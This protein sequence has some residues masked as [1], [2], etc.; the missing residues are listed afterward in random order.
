MTATRDGY[1]TARA[2]SDA[3]A[4]ARPG[5]FTTS[6]PPTITGDAQVDQTLTASPGSWSPEAAPAYQWLVDGDPVAG[7]TGPTYS[8]GVDDVRKQVSVQ[9]TMSLPGYDTAKVVSTATSA[10]VPGTFRNTSDASIAGTPRV[11]VTLTAD[12]GGWSPEPHFSWQWTADG[13]PISGAT[14][15]TFT[16]SPAEVGKR[17]AVEVTA[18]RPG[19]LTA[20]VESPVTA[21]VLPGENS[22]TQRPE[23]SGLPDVGETLTATPGTWAVA[24]SSVAYQWYADGV[25]IDGATSRRFTPGEAQLDQRLKVEVTARADG[26]EARTASSSATGPVVLGQVAFATGPSIS[27]TTLVGRTLTAATGRFTPSEA[28]PSYQ[29]LR[30]GDPIRGATG[31]TYELQPADV[32]YRVAV[33]VTLAAPHW[34]PTSAVARS[35]LVKSVPELTVS[36][37]SHATWAGISLRVVTPGLPDPDGK[38]RVYE[39]DELLGTIV[40]TDHRGYLRLDGLSAGTHH[41]VLRYTGPGPQAPASTRVD[42]PIG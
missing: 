2:T 34:A 13:E 9:V 10:V 33:R 27:G 17:L 31:R 8:P 4:K 36:V 11:D 7:A 38:A 19:Y 16:P 35:T 37:A 12:P 21:G 29:W 40:V 30:G 3:T 1:R 14:S 18:R 23:I 39:H 6:A 24:P 15:R 28:T 20:V 25:A 32:G 22:V 41:V 42:I 5:T 26:Y